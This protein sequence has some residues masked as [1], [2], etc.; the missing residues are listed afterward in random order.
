MKDGRN[1]TPADHRRAEA[2]ARTLMN[3]PPKPIKSV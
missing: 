3:M 1:I 2:V